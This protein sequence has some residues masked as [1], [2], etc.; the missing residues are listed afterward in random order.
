VAPAGH[1]RAAGRRVS[2]GRPG[3]LE[4]GVTRR[5]RNAAAAIP[6]GEFG[7]CDPRRPA[8]PTGASVRLT[9]VVL[10]IPTRRGGERSEGTSGGRVFAARKRA[11]DGQ[12]RHGFAGRPAPAYPLGRTAIGGACRQ[13]G[14]G[15]RALAAGRWQECISSR[16]LAAGH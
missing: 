1:S 12:C 15:S 5:S 14:V 11:P 8:S 13:P 2:A 6:R 10:V 16:A 9:S 3:T 7:P 4:R